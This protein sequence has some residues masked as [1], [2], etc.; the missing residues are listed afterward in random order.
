[1]GQGKFGS[2]SIAFR[3][4]SVKN[5]AI[6]LI[7][8]D[9]NE[10]RGTAY[11]TE[12]G[13]VVAAEDYAYAKAIQDLFE[14]ASRLKNQFLPTSMYQFLERW[15]AIFGIAAVPNATVIQRQNTISLFFQRWSKPPTL[16]TLT[17][18]AQQL[19]GSTFIKFELYDGMDA[20]ISFTPGGYSIPGGASILDGNWKSYVSFVNVDIWQPQDKYGNKLMDDA[21]YN[22][23]YNNF[24]VFFASYLPAYVSFGSRRYQTAGTGTISGFLNGSTI[25]G[26]GTNFTSILTKNIFLIDD[27][28]NPQILKIANI[29][30]DTQL[31]LSLPLT[32]SVTG[33]MS[34]F[35]YPGLGFL[36]DSINNLDNLRFSI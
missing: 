12:E 17:Y 8:K 32:T 4:G 33:C 2:G 5:Q 10:A 18:F 35:A 28:G 7:Y 15:E 1:M 24:Y 25:Y 36:L 11:D 23:L 31:T 30:S 29:A 19:L 34:Y 26:T 9:L 3:S 27:S 14:G 22:A 20:G 16:A 6:E 13:T 21:T